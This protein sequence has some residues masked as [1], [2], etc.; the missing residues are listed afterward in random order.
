MI[1]TVKRATPVSKYSIWATDDTLSQ[2]G[3]TMIK[4]IT[5]QEALKMLSQGKEVSYLDLETKEIAPL[6]KVLESVPG[7]YL[8]E[9]AGEPIE[10]T[11]PAPK[12]KP[13]PEP[14]IDLGKV[15]A[16]RRAGWPN[17]K[18]ADEMGVSP[19]TICYHLKKM[20]SEVQNESN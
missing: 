7:V 10:I 2:E 16:L 13:G 3:K 19:A 15:K 1:T 11:I 17:N 18:I 4:T 20:E 12:K 6:V 5:A 9:D 14:K 8:V